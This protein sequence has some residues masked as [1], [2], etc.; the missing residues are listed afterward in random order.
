MPKNAIPSSL[1]RKRESGKAWE[2]WIPAFAG[3]TPESSKAYFSATCRTCAK[4][5]HYT[6][7]KGAN[8]RA[9]SRSLSLPAKCLT[10]PERCVTLRDKMNDNSFIIEI[11]SV[12]SE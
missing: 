10:P 2:H 4:R 6:L 3:M 7:K 9:S 5:S 11:N 1:P 12:L 8:S